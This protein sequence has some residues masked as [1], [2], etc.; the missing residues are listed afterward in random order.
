MRDVVLVQGMATHDNYEHTHIHTLPNP[1]TQSA[2]LRYLLILFFS[3]NPFIFPLPAVISA[4]SQPVSGRGGVRSCRDFND[5]HEDERRGR[6]E[7]RRLAQ[8]GIRV[9]YNLQFTLVA[10]VPAL[11]HA[12]SPAVTNRNTHICSLIHFM[13]TGKSKGVT[14]HNP[15]F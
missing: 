9:F 2:R 5:A 12:C 8:E 11:I 10:C 13:R 14:R 15:L 7:E 1:H 3:F 4:C 6:R